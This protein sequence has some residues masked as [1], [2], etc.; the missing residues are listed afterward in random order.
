MLI[1]FT[2]RRSGKVFTTPVRYMETDGTVRCFTSA[3]NQWW[4]NLRGGADVILRINGV[5]RPYKATAISD[6]PEAIRKWLIHYLGEFPQ[7]AD[8]HDIRLTADKG[9]NPEDLEQALRKAIVV[10]A[11]PV[12]E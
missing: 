7:D 11:E 10:E 8:Y 6:D 1:T 9:L 12:R 2:G 3:E 5:D 4:R